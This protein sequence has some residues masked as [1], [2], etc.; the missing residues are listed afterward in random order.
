[1]NRQT[2]KDFLKSK[3]EHLYGT[4]FNEI[5]DGIFSILYGENY[6]SIKQKRDL[7][8]DGIIET[9]KISLACYAPE[10]YDKPKFEKK[11]DEDYGKYKKNYMSLGYKWRFI[12]NQ[13][14]LGSIVTYIKNKS[15]D[16]EVWG[17]EE[18]INFILNLPP[19]KR[20][21]ILLDIFSLS[22]ELIEF[23]FVE[24]VIEEISKLKKEVSDYCPQYN[25][26][27]DT[28]KKIEKNFS[29][30]DI[31]IVKRKFIHFYAEYIGYLQ[32]VLN[33]LDNDFISNMKMTVLR[34]YQFLYKKLTFKE[35]FDHLVN[36][37][38]SKYPKDQEYKNYVE[39]ILLYLFEQC[40][41]GTKSEVDK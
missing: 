34:E 19:S 37:F 14:L 32:K 28:S 17:I 9:E 36:R 6:K 3:I 27:K 15:T 4:Q 18:L 41:I 29:G 22:T 13:K 39:L 23:D 40:L 21:K 38:S 35:R 1:M 8:S 20:R 5:V 16:A 11:V 30:E 33:T 31:E 7:G 24:E 2:L 12:T 10:R 25:L 26:P